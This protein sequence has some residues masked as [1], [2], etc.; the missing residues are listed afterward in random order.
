MLKVELQDFD[1]LTDAEKEGASDNGAGKEWANYLRMTHNGETV[2]LEND[3]MQPE[4]VRFTRDL[5]WV[6][7]AIRRA[8][9]LGLSDAPR[10]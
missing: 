10:R 7:V 9:E 5:A 1:A 2:F 8:Y 4:D 3:A 6:L